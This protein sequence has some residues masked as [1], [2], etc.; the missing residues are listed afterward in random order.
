M[1]SINVNT[2]TLFTTALVVSESMRINTWACH[3]TCRCTGAMFASKVPVLKL[4]WCTCMFAAPSVEFPTHYLKSLFNPSITSETI[5]TKAWPVVFFALH[6]VHQSFLDVASFIHISNDNGALALSRYAL[7]CVNFHS[8][9]VC[10]F[11]RNEA[12]DLIQNNRDDRIHGS[13][14]TQK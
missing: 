4:L 8:K 10:Y 14:W 2:D 12:T 5:S 1:S 9:H 6:N 13:F 3:Q 7:R 11:F